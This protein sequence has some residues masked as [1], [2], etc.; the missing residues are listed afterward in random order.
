MTSICTYISVLDLAYSARNDSKACFVQNR[1]ECRRVLVF[2][3]CD[4]S[5]MYP[6]VICMREVCR[7]LHCPVKLV[8][9]NVGAFSYDLY[10]Y[11]HAASYHVDVG[12]SGAHHH[13]HEFCHF[14]ENYASQ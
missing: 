7:R 10:H 14:A 9:F 1:I 6:D 2:S 8:V 4:Q 3:S 13:N 5:P 12:H 11:H